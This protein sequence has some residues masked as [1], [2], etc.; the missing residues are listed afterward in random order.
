MVAG[1]VLAAGEGRRFGPKPKQ[2][3]DLGGQPILERVVWN[4]CAVPA[5]ERIVVVLGAHADEIRARVDFLDAEP[6]ICPNWRQGQSASL[7]A[8]LRALEGARKVIVLLGDQ[9]LVTPQV[10]ARFV[11]EPVGSRATYDGVPGHPAS[12]GPRLIR[13]ALALSGDRGLRDARWRPVECGRL[14]NGRDID[15]PDDLEAIRDEARAVL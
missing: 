14:A 7:R 13:Q 8:G 6:V 4:A 3:A 11:D 15:T 1:L 10:I 9:P 2:L 12:L 5:L